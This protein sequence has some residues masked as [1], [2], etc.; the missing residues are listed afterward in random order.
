MSLNAISQKNTKFWKK[1]F[2]GVISDAYFAT[3]TA[4]FF[5]QI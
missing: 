4:L 2:R 3:F 1:K 5:L